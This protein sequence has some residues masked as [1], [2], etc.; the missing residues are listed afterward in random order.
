MFTFTLIKEPNKFKFM[1]TT[2]E[3][4]NRLVELCRVGDY[5]TAYDELFH[6]EVK[7]TEPDH[8]PGPKETIGIEALKKKGEFFNEMIEEMHSG[9]VSDPLVADNHFTVTMGYEA[10]MK[11]RGRV[12]ESEVVVYKVENGKIVSEQY[13]F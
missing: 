5:N 10:T 4:A 7:A 11:G 9:F 13:F 8:A 3:I 1:N 12:T 2:Q 6:P